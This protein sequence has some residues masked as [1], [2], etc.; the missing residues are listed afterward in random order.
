MSDAVCTLRLRRGRAKPLHGGHPW[1]FADAVAG[2]EG[3]K[4]EAGDEVRVVDADA[5]V[6]GRGY[7]SP[8]SAIAVRL[9]TRGDEP[10]GEELLARRL[11]EALALRRDVLGLAVGCAEDPSPPANSQKPPAG[12]TTAFRLVHSEGDGLGGLIVD[13]YGPYLCVQI[14]TAGMDRRRETLLG[15]LE[16]R[17]EPRGILDKSDARMRQL[18]KLPPPGREPL[19]GAAPEGPFEV[20]ENGV[21]LLADLRPGRGQKTGLYLDQRENRARFAAFAAGRE[22]LDV[23]AYT[24]AFSLCAARAGAKSLTLIESSEPSLNAARAN[25]E[26]SGVADADLV[27]ADWTEG[28]RHL[29]EGNRSFDLVVLDPPKFARSKDAAVQALAGYR[30]LNA[31]AARLIRPGGIL[32]T[33]SCSGNV[34]ETD[35]ERAV[36]GALSHAGRRAALLERRGA[37]PDHPVPPGFEQGA[38]LKCLVLRLA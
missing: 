33:C 16:T 38:Y 17:L 5:H 35:F 23:F 21:A 2:F 36:A 27:C 37:A 31:Q 6:L 3:S 29:R 14:G 30:E 19:R 8:G 9:L 25:L 15:L 12:P 26:H 34:P 20:F 22:V 1:V 32:F 4:A 7:Y 18:E 24:G 11:D 13:Q 28:F 10:A